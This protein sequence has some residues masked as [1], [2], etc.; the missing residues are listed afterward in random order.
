MSGPLPDDLRVAQQ[1]I[2]WAGHIV[3]FSP[4]WLGTMPT[5]VKVFLEQTLRLGFAVDN[6]VPRA[7]GNAGLS[8]RSA[9]V[10]SSS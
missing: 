10:T 4:L 6:T 2:Q 8:G 3:L 1:A 5:L 7:D 9:Y